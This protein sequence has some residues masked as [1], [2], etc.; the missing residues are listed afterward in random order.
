V[1]PFAP[2]RSALHAARA[3]TAALWCLVLAG[4][5]LA[6]EHPLALAALA[7]ALAGA[8]A[9][10][11]AG[12]AVARTARFA[13][14]LALLVALV[15]PFV[16]RDGTTVLFR[17]GEVPPLGQ[18]D[19]T[20]EATAYGAVLG[21]RT[22]LVVLACALLTAVVDPDELLRALR[23]VSLRGGLTA[24]LA[25][26][27]LP[28]LARDGR[29][30]AEGARLRARPP[31]RVA[32]ARAVAS[33]ALDRAVDV[34]ATLE[35]RGYGLPGRPGAPAQPRSR[36][37]AALAASAL[38]LAGLVAVGEG[39]GATSFAAYPTLEAAGGP[40]TLAA[41]GALVAVVLLPFAQRRGIGG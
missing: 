6:V 35:V 3:T 41:C 29:R 28:V 23:R 1:T 37:D 32:L 30:L 21:A 40:A 12:R 31:G 13:A 5:A 15:N 16:V 22:L 26:R 10:A 7:L 25:V 33:G 36:H 9:L 17:V 38:A 19:L 39:T 2:G 4:A 27:L 24:A 20:L 18:V 34:A 11:G 8:A 14:P